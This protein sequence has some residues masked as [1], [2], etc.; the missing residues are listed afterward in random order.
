M[1]VGWATKRKLG[2][3]GLDV[4]GICI[5]TSPLASI[6]R[7]YGYGVDEDRAVSTIRAVFDSPFN[8]MDTSNS[9]GGG[10]GERR[11]GK[12]IREAGGLPPGFVLA[13]KA[14]ANK[15]TR[16]FSGPRVRQSVEESIER[17]GIE[18]FQLMYL[19][20]PEYYMTVPE[21]MAPGGP[22][23]ALVKLKEEGVIANIGIAAGPI[24]MLREFIA[25]GVFQVVLSHNRYTLIDRSAEPLMEEARARNVAFVNAAPFGGGILVKGPDAQVNYA[26][27]PAVEPVRA[28]VAKMLEACAKYGVPLAA[29]A[30]QFSLRDPRVTVTAV[31]I[32]EPERIAKTAA[33][34]DHPIPA[35]LWDEL[36]ALAVPSEHWLK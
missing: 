9:Y 7:I 17:L 12:A 32:S 30:L 34:A 5:G 8:F 14:D 20:D 22:V 35:P 11:I 29:A 27:K 31:G 2:E 21:A 25:T 4:T 13:T 28:A 6:P 36:N 1:T 18:R 15:Q 33:L 10:D 3:T 19:H 24:P 23:E 26:Y 16:D